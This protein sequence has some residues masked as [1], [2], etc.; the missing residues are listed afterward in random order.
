MNTETWIIFTLTLYAVSII[1]GPSMMIA[2]THGMRYGAKATLATV[3]GNTLASALQTIIS[4]AGLGVIIATSG[5]I[6]LAIKYAGALY[7]IYLGIKLWRSPSW[8]IQT[9]NAQQKTDAPLRSM[10]KQGF[11]IAAGNP[12]AIVFFSALF[13]QFINPETMTDDYHQYALVVLTTCSSA[14]FCAL[15]YAIG[16]NQLGVIFKRYNF[17]KIL[18]KLTG[19]F[20]VNSGLGL[21]LSS[22]S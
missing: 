1:P 5:S 15:L 20:F 7:L 9:Q 21:L 17:S 16:G 18:N 11:I 10:F 19:V 12:K 4:I 13:P 14:F 3:L 8:G 2:L 6:F 22:R